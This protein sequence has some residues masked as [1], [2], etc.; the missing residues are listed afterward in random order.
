MLVL[1]RKVGECIVIDGGIELEIL[2]IAGSRVRLGIA[3]PRTCQIVRAELTPAAGPASP[4]SQV[5]ASPPVAV[6]PS[7]P[8]LQKCLA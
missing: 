3:A 7:P 8:Q 1:S 4:S 6:P 2:Q 5:V